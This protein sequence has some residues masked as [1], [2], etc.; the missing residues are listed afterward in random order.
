MSSML[1]EV[2]ASRTVADVAHHR[3][4]RG[5]PG[6]LTFFLR[7]WFN[8]REWGCSVQCLVSKFQNDF[9]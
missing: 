6:E 7:E 1:V 9:V 3:F 5:T 4:S 2:L 8:L